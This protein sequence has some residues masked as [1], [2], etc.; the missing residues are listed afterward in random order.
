MKLKYIKIEDFALV[1]GETYL[2]YPHHRV[3]PFGNSDYEL[4][5]TDRDHNFWEETYD[6]YDGFRTRI[7]KPYPTH[8]CELPESPDEN[9]A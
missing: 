7:A 4:E 6:P 3:L 9:E 8:V 5:G 1:R 2:T